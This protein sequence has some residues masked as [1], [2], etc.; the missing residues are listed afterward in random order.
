MKPFT[1]IDCNTAPIG[2]CRLDRN[3]IITVCNDWLTALLGPDACGKTL[4]D[5]VPCAE[6]RAYGQRLW[7]NPSETAVLSCGDKW[8]YVAGQSDKHGITLYWCD[9]TFVKAA[10]HQADR[11]A[12]QKSNFLAT[13][14]HEIRTPMQSI[15]GLLEMIELERPSGDVETMARTAKQSASNLLE[16]LDGVLDFAKMDADQMELDHFEVPVRTLCRG[17]IEALEVKVH[18]DKVAFIDLVEEDVP[19]VVMGDPKRLRQ[20]LINLTGNAL[21]F[22]K[23]GTVAIHIST[24]ARH[25]PVPEKGFILRFEVIDTGIGLSADAQMRLFQPFSQAD[26]STSRKYGGT[27]L[28]LSICKKLVELMGGKIGVDSVEGKGSTFWFEI[29]TEAC[30]TRS[31]TQILPVLDGITVLS[32]EDHPRG[33]K[34]IQKALRSMG[35][36]VEHCFTIK[37]A[38]VLLQRRP[39]DVAI[40]DQGL[41]DGLGID[42]IREAISLRPFMGLIMYTARDDAG[43][44][45]TLNGLGV[46]YLSK[47]ASRIGLGEAVYDAAA[48]IHDRREILG[49]KKLLIAEDTASVRDVLKRQLDRLGVTADFV[50]NGEQALEA[51]HS[52]EYGILFTDLHMPKIDGYGVVKAIREDDKKLDRHFPVIALTADVQMSQRHIYMEQGFDECLLKPVSLGHFKRLLMRWGLLTDDMTLPNISAAPIMTS[53]TAINRQAIIDQMGAFDEG[54]VDML[55]MFADMTRPLI[56][57]I[58]AAHAAGDTHALHEAAHSLKG[59]ARSACALQLGDLAAELQDRADSLPVADVLI[60]KINRAFEDVCAEIERL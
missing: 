55:K 35:A 13:M 28:G 42:L 32:V 41:P 59:A 20:I 5:A 22:T 1:D 14:S 50:E 27:G 38:L 54:V 17:I 44:Q 25:L 48:R 8:L 6:A 10:A 2:L 52:G 58:K 26:N 34:E 15:F 16:L 49:A 45:H 12:E 40:I 31:A 19:P 33:A 36:V 47:P 7:D 46:T 3:Q 51:M 56:D 21:K 24:N 23:E 60:P 18:G 4:A 9:I 39:F 30:D 29:P 43:L 11:L 53:Q 57:V 37:D